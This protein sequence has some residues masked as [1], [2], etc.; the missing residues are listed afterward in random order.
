MF[1]GCWLGC[2]SAQQR[3]AARAESINPSI[4]ICGELGWP[5]TPPA[6]ASLGTY[7]VLPSGD[8]S[9]LANRKCRNAN[10]K[11]YATNKEKELHLIVKIPLVCDAQDEVTSLSREG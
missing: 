1:I 9:I 3:C 4:I 6:A 7:F 5:D 2:L 10:K 11:L 8:T